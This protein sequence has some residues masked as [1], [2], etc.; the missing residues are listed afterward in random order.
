M[1]DVAL[2]KSGSPENSMI[3]QAIG[4]YFGGELASPLIDAAVQKMSPFF[5][6]NES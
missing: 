2:N 5:L 4:E 1:R 6:L 3:N